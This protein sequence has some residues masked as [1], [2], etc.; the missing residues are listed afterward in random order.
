[1]TYSDGVIITFYAQWKANTPTPA[2]C[3][4]GSICYD[5][6]GANSVTKMGNQDWHSGSTIVAATLWASNF[7]RSGY[8]FAGWNTKADGTGTNYGPNETITDSNVLNTI[9]T[10]G[11]RLYAIWVEKAGDLQSW[12]GCSKLGQGKVTALRDTRD[13]NVYAVAKLA[14]G[15]CWMVENLRLNDMVTISSSNTDSPISGFFVLLRLDVL[16][17]RRVI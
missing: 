4:A 14:D 7:Q 8:G 5:D 12:S 17:V 2:A 9:Q 3:S 16:R 13:G 11:L 6:N 10:S 1:M 15:K